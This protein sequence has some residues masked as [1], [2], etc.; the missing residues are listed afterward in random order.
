MTVVRT[1]TAVTSFLIALGLASCSAQAQEQGE[2]TGEQNEDANIDPNES[3]FDANATGNETGG[4]DVRS[5]FDPDFGERGDR[6]N[7]T[8]EEESPTVAIPLVILGLAAILVLARR[9]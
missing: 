6:A 5:P 7:L 4:V 3:D 8:D 1:L 9:R 2:P